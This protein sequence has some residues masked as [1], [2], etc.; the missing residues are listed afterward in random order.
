MTELSDG[1]L[2][3][4]SGI[5]RLFSRLKGDSATCIPPFTD[6]PVEPDPPSLVGCASVVIGILTAL[7]L[8]LAVG[9]LL[10]RL[11]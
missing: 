2:E 8:L 7:L 11:L 1:R 10:S 9:E 5:K 6:S 3:A 4:M